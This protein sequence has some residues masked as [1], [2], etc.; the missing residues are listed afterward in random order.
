MIAY[1]HLFEPWARDGQMPRYSAVFLVD[2][3]DHENIEAIEAAIQAAIEKGMQRYAGFD[4]ATCRRPLREGSESLMRFMENCLAINARSRRQ[5]GVVDDMVRYITDPEGI[6][7]GCI[8]NASLDFYP[9]YRNGECGVA[10][11]LGNVQ[12]VSQEERQDIIIRA[13]HEFRPLHDF[14]DLPF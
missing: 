11:G 7:S 10:A 13:D 5:P 8:V 6:W 12:L 2:R 3:S 1:P 4:P 14:E 9:W